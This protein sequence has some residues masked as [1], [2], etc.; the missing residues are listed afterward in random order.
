MQKH[1][2]QELIE[3]LSKQ[4]RTILDESAQA[5]VIYLDDSHKVC[6]Q[7]F[8]DMLGYRSPED[9]A[10]MPT[11]V[12]DST[13]DTRDALITAVMYALQKKASSAVRVAWKTKYDGEVNTTCVSVPGAFQGQTY[14]MLFFET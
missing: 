14:A 12:T 8:A 7:K 6:N 4:L 3:S 11:P 13:E 10:I 9:W 1:P 2:D 5:M